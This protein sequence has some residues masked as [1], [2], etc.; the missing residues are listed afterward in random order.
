MQ[1]GFFA[2]IAR[3]K[4]IRRWGLMRNTFVEDVQGHSH[5]TA[6]IAHT[7]A[8]IR[9]REFGG[10]ID[11][12]ECAAA[13][14]YHDAPEIITGDLPTPVKYHDTHLTASY[15][16]VEVLAQEKLLQMLPDNLRNDFAP[17]LDGGEGEVHEL[18]SAADKLSAYI[19]CV[20]E[21]LAGN[22]EFRSAELQI[23][24]TLEHSSLPE[25]QYFLN[26]FMPSFG[27]TLDELTRE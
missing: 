22:S 25:V 11:A 6:V 27:L 10:S 12:G 4:N 21:R 2:L 16:L 3:M 18:V 17:L 5:M 13:A 7:L 23:L 19:K 20:E 8:V 15:K 9:N 14:L 24:A 1:N 26:N